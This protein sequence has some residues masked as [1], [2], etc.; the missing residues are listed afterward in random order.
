MNDLERAV[1]IALE[2]HTGQTDKAGC[3]VERKT[4]PVL[5]I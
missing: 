2:A 3:S 5:D 1:D 4:T